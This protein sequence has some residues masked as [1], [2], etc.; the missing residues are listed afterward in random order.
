MTIGK[1]KPTDAIEICESGLPVP[2]K[3]PRVEDSEKLQFLLELPLVDHFYIGLHSEDYV[4]K[5]SSFDEC[6]KSKT[7]RN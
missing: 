1:V 3:L 2:G 5:C 7:N 6:F 4:E